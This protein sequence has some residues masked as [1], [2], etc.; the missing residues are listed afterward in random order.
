LWPFTGLAPT[1][2]HPS[3]AGGLVLDKVLQMGSYMGRVQRA[4]ISFTLLAT[5]LLM[6][7]SFDAVPFSHVGR[8]HISEKY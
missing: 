3:C 4:V 1:A 6:I 8:F 2:P 7:P 5:F